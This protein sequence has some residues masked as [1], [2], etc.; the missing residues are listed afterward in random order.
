MDNQAKVIPK[1]N[2]KKR[3]HTDKKDS[4]WLRLTMGVSLIYLLSP[5]ICIGTYLIVINYIDF[6][7]ERLQTSSSVISEEIIALWCEHELFASN[8][9][10]CGNL[11]ESQ[12]LSLINSVLE[13]KIEDSVISQA[14]IDLL[15]SGYFSK[16][17][18]N[19][20]PLLGYC[21][22]YHKDGI[23]IIVSYNSN[24]MSITDILVQYER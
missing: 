16:E 19:D 3:E 24:N 6:H 7:H 11:I 15:L 9:Q 1:M 20:H 13:D 8:K 10:I 21:C 2:K 22:K 4:F 17:C 23:E 18:I 14:D 12:E 5:V